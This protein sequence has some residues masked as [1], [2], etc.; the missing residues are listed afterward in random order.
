MKTSVFFIFFS[1]KKIFISTI[2]EKLELPLS[3]S[4]QVSVSILSIIF[5]SLDDS[6][7]YLFL[8]FVCTLEGLRTYEFVIFYFIFLISKK[9]TMSA[10]PRFDIKPVPADENR[11]DDV[12]QKNNFFVFFETK[13]KLW[14]LWFLAASSQLLGK[15]N[16]QNNIK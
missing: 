10:P 7:N 1:P 11:S 16:H 8:F 4:W 6:Q 14:I 15:F 5:C 2:C 3:W 9:H 13:S 12:S